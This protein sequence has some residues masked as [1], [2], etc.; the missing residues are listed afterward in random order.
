MIMELME[1][2]KKYETDSNHV[3]NNRGEGTQTFAIQREMSVIHFYR[4]KLSRTSSI[5]FFTSS[6]QTGLPQPFVDVF[7]FVFDPVVPCGRYHTERCAYHQHDDCYHTEN[8][9]T[10]CHV[11]VLLSRTSSKTQSSSAFSQKQFEP[12]QLFGWI[13][14]MKVIQRYFFLTR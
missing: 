9:R 14:G 2:Y 5:D 1:F 13:S 8:K 7:W 3:N 12:L 10:Y 4:L 6:I 11:S